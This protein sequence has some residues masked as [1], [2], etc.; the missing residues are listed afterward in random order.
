MEI[1]HRGRGRQS[2]RADILLAETA[3]AV[4]IG[5]RVRPDT[6]AR[7]LAER[8]D[9]DVHTYDV[10]YEAVEQVR[11]ALEGMLAPE[12]RENVAGTA[13]VRAI[14]KVTKVGTIAG[15]YVTNGV[16]TRSDKVHLI[17]DGVLVYDGLISSLKRFKDDAREVRE[18]FECGIGIENYNDL[19]VGDVIEAYSVE[20]VAR[21]LD[22]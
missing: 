10:I 21:T 7:L 5:F 22:A 16:I 8:E 9:V 2:T 12:R 11:S 18:G 13:E 3:G 17:R 6:N 20:E 15:C 1:I 4:V 19:K 14:F